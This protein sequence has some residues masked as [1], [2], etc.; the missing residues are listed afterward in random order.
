MNIFC[1]G[2]FFFLHVF[3]CFPLVLQVKLITE[4]YLDALTFVHTCSRRKSC[5][6]VNNVHRV[7]VVFPFP[8][9]LICLLIFALGRRRRLI[10]K[11]LSADD[12]PISSCVPITWEKSQEYTHTAA[13]HGQSYQLCCFIFI[14]LFL[15]RTGWIHFTDD[16]FQFMEC[17]WLVN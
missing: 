17:M 5:I 7:P 9:Q 16:C 11:H 12:M 3:V 15:I 4:L 2:F 1:Q 8:C 10:L 14:L 6:W 13:V